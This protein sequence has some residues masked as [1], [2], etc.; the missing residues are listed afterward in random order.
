MK[1]FSCIK[2]GR[3]KKVL[4]KFFPNQYRKKSIKDD[5]TSQIS[6]VVENNNLQRCRNSLEVVGKLNTLKNNYFKNALQIQLFLR[7]SQLSDFFRLSFCLHFHG[8]P[9][10]QVTNTLKIITTGVMSS[11]PF[12]TS[13]TS[14][15][16]NLRSWGWS[17]I[18]YKNISREHVVARQWS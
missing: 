2:S 9:S 4:L 3:I 10:L 5:I 6:V 12:V 7:S 18:N 16:A 11:F 15:R 13:S 17:W 8:W 14:I 1:L